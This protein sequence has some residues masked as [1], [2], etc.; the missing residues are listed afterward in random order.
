MKREAMSKSRLCSFNNPDNVFKFYGYMCTENQFLTLLCA[1]ST[2][3][4]P[5][6]EGLEILLHTTCQAMARENPDKAD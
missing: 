4:F 3:Y 1:E 5:F 2:L 6:V